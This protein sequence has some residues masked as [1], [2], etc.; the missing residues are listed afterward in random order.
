MEFRDIGPIRASIVGV[1]CN[2]FGARVAREDAERI[3]RTALD[4]G[5]T[6]FDTADEYGGGR[7]EEFLG[8]ALAKDRS[9]AVISTKFGALAPEGGLRP[10]DPRWVMKAC[11]ASLS[12][13]GTDYIDLYY[14]HHPD[15]KT[16]IATT[17]EA[18]DTLV[19]QGKVRQIGC[20]NFSGEMLEEA[21]QAAAT[22]RSVHFVQIQNNYSLLDRTAELDV[23]PACERLG[24]M[25]EPYFP[26]ASGML[27]GK[28]RRTIPAPPGSRLSI[29][30]EYF[31]DLFTTECFDVVEGLERFAQDRGYTLHELALSWLA[32]RPRV[33]CVIA[34]A[35]DSE[36]LRAN[37][38]A[39][40]AWSLLPEDMKHID[41]L[42]FRDRSFTTPVQL[43]DGLLHRN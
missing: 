4:I 6:R 29:V 34:G 39:T 24:L 40:M 43:K 41:A 36:Q 7:S 22:A 28:Y 13:L 16:P 9:K 17:L 23:L 30:G 18:L 15:P 12:R 1:G 11:E 8:R 35:V 37:A 25:F 21:H 14:L 10:A 2:N 27:T 19:K 26:L 32:S 3:I 33:S 31:P 5:I 20:S 38:A 42:T